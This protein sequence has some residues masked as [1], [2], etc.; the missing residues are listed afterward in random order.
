VQPAQPP[1]SVGWRP[2]RVTAVGSLLFVLACAV[3]YGG[4]FSHAYPGDV[5]T[6]A[7]YGRALVL[8]GRI[9]YRDFYVEY[10]PGAVPVFT[11]PVLIWNAHY[12][13]VF[14][15]LMTA[16][17]VGMIG[18]S[19]WIIARLGLSPWRLAPLVLAPILMGPVFLNRYDAVPALLTAVAL[20]ALLRARERTAGALLGIGTAMKL[21]PA[22][23]VPVAIRRVRSLSGA[24]TAFLV[25]GAVLVLPFFLLAPGGVG[26][27]LWT[28]LKRHLQI[29]S[30]GASIL[31][32]GSKL[33]LHHEGWIKG[34][35][36]SIDLGGLAAD[37]V[38]ALTS[39]LAVA[40]VLVVAWVFWRGSDDDARNVTAWAA[41]VCAF[42]VFGKVLSPQYLTWLLPLVP[43]AAGKKGRSAAAV[44]LAALALTQFEYLIPTKDGLQQQTWMVWVLLLRNTLLV[45]VFAL[46]LAQLLE[47]GRPRAGEHGE[48]V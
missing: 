42:T 19:G 10:P 17:G 31:L 13:L 35:P 5:G 36:G 30:L 9:P 25:A 12:V 40:L 21:Y 15:L 1:R 14:K 4:L 6:Y 37:T 26:F 3:G 18:C 39:L 22:V 20:V 7:A 47:S 24:G 44:F 32:A 27:S 48:G 41:A 16:C 2:D 33:G 11:L 46:L 8:H 29:E 23:V 38:G 28:Q 45:V 34:K 43:L